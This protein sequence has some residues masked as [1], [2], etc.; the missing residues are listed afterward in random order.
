LEIKQNCEE[1]LKQKFSNCL[2]LSNEIIKE[3]DTINAANQTT[4]PTTTTTTATTATTPTTP[5]TTSSDNTTNSTNINT[6]PIEL[7]QKI[8][9]ELEDYC[10]HHHQLKH[11]NEFINRLVK[12]NNI[13]V[14]VHSLLVT[15]NTFN[16]KDINSGSDDKELKNIVVL[17]NFI[18]LNK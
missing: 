11:Y 7:I 14:S 12:S 10:S 6:I 15:N 9:L 5:T 8:L 17:F 4:L 2:E 18:L 13:P 3:F 1:F 16:C